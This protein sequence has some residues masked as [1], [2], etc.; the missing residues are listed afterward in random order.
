M[1]MPPRCTKVVVRISAVFDDLA[2]S[3]AHDRFP[4]PSA[5]RVLLIECKSD[6]VYALAT[7]RPIPH[8][9]RAL[10]AQFDDAA[11]LLKHTHANAKQ[12]AAGYNAGLK[13]E[14]RRQNPQQA[15]NLR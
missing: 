15:L 5:D 1:H 12:W 13:S 3:L 6:L 8:V 2:T 7:E 11:N 14:R 10:E 4:P 9:R